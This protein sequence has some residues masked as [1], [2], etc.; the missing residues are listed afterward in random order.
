MPRQI[1]VVLPEGSG[2]LIPMRSSGQQRHG[3]GPHVLW[4]RATDRP[5]V[6][7]TVDNQN[8]KTPTSRSTPSTWPT[9]WAPLPNDVKSIWIDEG[10]ETL[11]GL[12]SFYTSSDELHAEL[13]KVGVPQLH[14]DR[15]TL[16][17]NHVLKIPYD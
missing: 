2:L 17:E 16:Q 9:S 11:E 8:A 13:A 4:L 1:P 7:E 3:D 14:R 15:E 10:I 12:K 5:P 6:Q